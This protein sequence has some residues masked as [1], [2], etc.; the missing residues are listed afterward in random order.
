M[1]LFGQFSLHP[2]LNCKDKQLKMWNGNKYESAVK[3][4]SVVKPIDSIHKWRRLSMAATFFVIIILTSLVN[5]NKDQKNL[6]FM[7]R[8]VRM[9]S[10]KTN[11]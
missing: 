9:I 11:E 1:S 5:T 6:Y 8:L 4:I 2:I 7:A 3:D 10:I